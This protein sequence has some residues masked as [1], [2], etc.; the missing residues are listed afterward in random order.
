MNI[1]PQQVIQLIQINEKLKEKVQ[2]LEKD[3]VRFVTVMAEVKLAHQQQL[4]KLAEELAGQ[5]LLKMLFGQNAQQGNINQSQDMGRSGDLGQTGEIGQSGL[6]G[7]SADLGTSGDLQRSQSMGPEQQEK[8]AA[9]MQKYVDRKKVDDGTIKNLTDKLNGASRELKEAHEQIEQLVQE[10]NRL[11][12][13]LEDRPNPTNQIDTTNLHLSDLEMKINQELP[14][15]PPIA[16]QES[17]LNEKNEMQTKLT[18]LLG[19]ERQLQQELGKQLQAMTS[20]EESM[21]ALRVQKDAEILSLRTQ[22]E[23]AEQRYSKEITSIKKAVENSRTQTSQEAEQLR[24]L[25][26]TEENR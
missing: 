24:T 22:L 13:L 14:P 5:N 19:K 2:S 4:K 25:I 10:I 26:R 8:L 20:L 15:A 11:K 12:E 21:K 23:E 7:G 16:R 3:R 17:D 1:G 6:V 18:K 9:E